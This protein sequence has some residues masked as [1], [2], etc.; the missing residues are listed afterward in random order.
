[1]SRKEWFIEIII[2]QIL[3]KIFNVMYEAVET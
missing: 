3:L 1:M 2:F